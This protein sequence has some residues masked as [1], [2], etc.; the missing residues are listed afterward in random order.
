LNIAQK[1]ADKKD[2]NIKD[3]YDK[4]ILIIFVSPQIDEA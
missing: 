3:S 1:K 4:E 2:K